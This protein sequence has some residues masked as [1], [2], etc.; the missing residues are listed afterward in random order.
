M[1]FAPAP[2]ASGTISMMGSLSLVQPRRP[3]SGSGR[4]GA[5]GLRR[6]VSRAR[7]RADAP[8]HLEPPRQLVVAQAAFADGAV[9]QAKDDFTSVLRSARGDTGDEEVQ[10]KLKK[11]GEMCAE[12]V[13]ADTSRL[14][15]DFSII[16]S[17][18]FPDCLGYDSNGNPQYTLG[19]MSF[20]MFEPKSTKCSI[21]D[22]DNVVSDLGGKRFSYDVNVIFEV[23]DDADGAAGI[24]GLMSTTGSCELSEDAG[25]ERGGR[26]NVTFT[27]GTISPRDTT[28]LAAWNSVFGES[29]IQPPGIMDKVGAWI[30]GAV[31]GIDKPLGGGDMTTGVQRFSMNRAP[32]GWLDV[33]FMDDELRVTRGNRGSIVAVQRK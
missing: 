28:D 23:A 7:R 19:R 29:S 27:G 26:L 17:P 25:D 5:P 30:M 3:P 4:T 22:I 1:R 24:Q 33:I 8:Q 6:G 31:L 11:L 12:G 32:Q 20:G 21:L 10:R 14:C 18:D 2:V 13:S 9:K 15:G 16:T